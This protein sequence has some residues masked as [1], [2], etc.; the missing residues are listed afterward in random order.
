[1]KK[2]VKKRKANSHFDFVMRNN[3]LSKSKCSQSQVVGAVVLILIV[4]A[5]AMVIMSF[6]IPFIRDQLS[7]TECLDVAGKI[8]IK[9]NPAYTCYDLPTTNMSVQ[10]LF[11]DIQ[12]LT[13]GFQINVESGG[14]SKSVSVISG[15]TDEVYML[16]GGAVEVP[17]KNEERTYIITGINSLPDSVSVYPILNNDKTCDASDVMTTVVSC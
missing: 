5:S 14:S 12:N 13:K 3:I 10:I 16:N 15:T 1:M 7:G 17:G 8:L 2:M 4:I 11:K 9:N 6:I